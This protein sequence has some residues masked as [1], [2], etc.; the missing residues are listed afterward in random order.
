ML[1]QKNLNQIGK[2]V[3]KK[4]TP[5]KTDIKILK[6]DTKILKADMDILKEDVTKIRKDINVI[7]GF[8]DREYLNLRKRV[9]RLEEHLNLPPL[10]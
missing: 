9:K 1:T 2:I 6:K 3:E 10:S 4:L 5:I 8:F 7:V